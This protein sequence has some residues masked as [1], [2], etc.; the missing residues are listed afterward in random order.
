MA[1]KR[2]SEVITVSAN[3]SQGVV[4]T[5]ETIPIDLQLNPLDQEVFV[6]TAVKLDF[7]GILPNVSLAV[8]ATIFPVERIA[9]SSTRP[10]AMLPASAGA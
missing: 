2:S 9:L 8:P 1:L 10:A 4:N 6:V 7:L 5:F 3:R